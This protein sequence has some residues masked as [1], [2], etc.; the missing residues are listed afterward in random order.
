MRLANEFE[1][2]A[3]NKRT[4]IQARRVIESLHRELTGEELPSKSLADFVAVWLKEKEPETSSATFKAYKTASDKLLA[5]LGDKA[6]LDV[7]LICHDDL[8]SFRNDAAVNRHSTTVNNVIK[9]VRM[10]FKAAHRKRLITENPAEFLDTVK[11]SQKSERRPFKLDEL[12]AVLAVADAEWQSMIYFGLYTGQRLGDVARLTW[13]NVDTERGMLTLA[14]AKTGRRM[15]LPLAEPLRDHIA[16]LTASDT[17]NA[18]L[19]PR[20]IAMIKARGNSSALSR[21]FGE[22]L[23]LAG[24]R[25]AGTYSIGKGRVARREFSELSFHCLRH[26]ASTMLREAGVPDAVVM[27][28][29]GHDDPQMSRH[30]THVGKDALASAAAKMPSLI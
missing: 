24:L 8:M 9:I 30:Y 22:L 14:T 23:I 29:I 19:H 1:A 26:T 11:E 13:A 6:A 2:A 5:F 10:I 16:R 18:P 20:A 4:A 27:E 25:A 3:N 17:P 28:Y 21:Q 12:R 15:T 7:S